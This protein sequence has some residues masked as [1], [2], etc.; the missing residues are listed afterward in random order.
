MAQRTRHRCRAHLPR[1]AGLLTPY[2]HAGRVLCGRAARDVAEFMAIAKAV[3]A[4]A[5][6]LLRRA[7]Q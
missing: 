2:R 1:A 7:M 6:E 5:V 4:D 3:N